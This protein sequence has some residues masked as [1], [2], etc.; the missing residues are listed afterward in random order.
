M[1]TQVTWLRPI[2]RLAGG[3]KARDHD[4]W[5]MV[6]KHAAY[7]VRAQVTRAHYSHILFIPK[8]TQVG[9][10][11][12]DSKQLCREMYRTENFL[13]V[14]KTSPSDP[15]IGPKIPILCTPS[16]KSP[17]AS[18][19]KSMSLG[20]YTENYQQALLSLRSDSQKAPFNQWDLEGL[21]HRIGKFCWGKELAEVWMWLRGQT[22]AGGKGWE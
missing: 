16:D 7:T 5:L 17:V 18:V 9:L 2:G 20:S 21:R 13:P 1:C 19:P 6:E 14:K 22:W 4:S 12:E 15:N 8:Q 11:L 10:S 3:N